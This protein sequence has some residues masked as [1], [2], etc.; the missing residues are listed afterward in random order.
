MI[1]LIWFLKDFLRISCRRQSQIYIWVN[2]SRRDLSQTHWPAGSNYMVIRVKDKFVWFV[3][4]VF[5]KY[6]CVICEICVRNKYPCEK[7]NAGVPN[8]S[9]KRP[10]HYPFFNFFL[11]KDWPHGWSIAPETIFSFYLFTKNL[12]DNLKNKPNN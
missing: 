3:R 10:H 1:N 11:V 8:L 7:K 12:I 4:F 9:W 2:N 5:E 6:F